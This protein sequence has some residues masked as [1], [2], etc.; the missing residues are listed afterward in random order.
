M[1]ESTE[2]KLFH[3]L[4]GAAFMWLWSKYVRA[5]NDKKHCTAC[6]R[7][8]YSKRLSR[9]NPELLA[10]G[11]LILD[12]VLPEEFKAIYICGVARKGYSVK[13]NY[14]YNLHA[15]ILPK[16][17]AKDNFEFDKWKLSVENGVFLPIPSEKELPK[18]YQKLEPEYTTCRIFRWAVCA[19]AQVPGLKLA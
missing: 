16:P 4:D 18:V 11:E 2:V 3:N 1:S 13:K 6:L 17:G 8:P 19:V 15:A 12:E 5:I 10:K 14:P 7:G 9:H